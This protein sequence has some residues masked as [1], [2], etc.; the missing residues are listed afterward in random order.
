LA[1]YDRHSQVTEAPLWHALE[2]GATARG[3]VAERHGGSRSHF[4]ELSRTRHRLPADLPAL[5]FALTPQMHATER[6]QLV[7]SVPMQELVTAAAVELAGGR[8]VHVGPLTLRQ[9]FPTAAA[10]A[11]GPDQRTDVGEGY[12]AEHVPGATDP[13][14]VA[15]ALAAWTLAVG[16]AHARGGATTLTLFETWGPRGVVD[17]E[18]TAYPVAEVVAWLAEARDADLWSPDEPPAPDVWVAGARSG[19]G[20]VRFV[21]NLSDVPVVVTV[22][23]PGEP[24]WTVDVEPYACRRQRPERATPAGGSPQGTD[25]TGVLRFHHHESEGVRE[26]R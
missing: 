21:A 4:T 8:P 24:D 19:S 2:E 15:P 11:P 12:G 20:T 3:L 1:V 7:E 9:R 23:A 14:Q 25:H 6:A 22:T 18:G 17:A 13:R 10:V 16:I 5:G 26:W